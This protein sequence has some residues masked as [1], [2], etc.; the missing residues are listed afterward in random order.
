MIG[1]VGPRVI[2]IRSADGDRLLRA[3]RRVPLRI[4][5]FV[6][7]GCDDGDTT[8]VK[9]KMESHVSDVAATF[10]PPSAYPFNRSVNT[11]GKVV[12]QAR[13]NNRGNAGPLCLLGDPIS[14]LDTV[15][16]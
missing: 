2:D 10:H 5:V 12:T 15:V 4:Q 13:S 6:S 14:A 1:E 9:L 3:G 8:V 11:E 7:S 16:Q